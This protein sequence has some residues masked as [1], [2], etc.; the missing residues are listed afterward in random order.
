MKIQ[1]YNIRNGIKIWK[2]TVP[3][4]DQGHADHMPHTPK[5][6][7]VVTGEIGNGAKEVS[8]KLK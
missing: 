1:Y 7:A 2:R 6:G 3:L 8:M 4:F 5:Y